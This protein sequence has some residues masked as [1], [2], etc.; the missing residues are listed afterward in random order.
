[1]KTDYT[2]YMKLAIRLAQKA[3]GMTSPNPLVGAVIIDKKGKI[4]G[5]GFH[6]MA[7]QPHA[8]IMALRDAGKVPADST[9]VVTLEPCNHFGR[10]PPCT[11]AI[12]Q[13][14]I[15]RVVIAN[16]DPNPDVEGG[17]AAYLKKA[18]IEVIDG[19]CEQDA[20]R[21]NEAYF[22][23]VKTS[24]PFVSLKL[25]MSLDG[26]IAAH[27]GSSKW[28]TSGYSRRIAH[29]LRNIVDAVIVGVGTVKMDNPELTVRHVKVR[30]RPLYRIIFD[31][32]LSTP[33]NSNV[34]TNQNN[35]YKTMIL[36]ASNNN[37]LINVFEHKDVEVI[38][39]KTNGSVLSV[40]EALNFLG[41][42]FMH[43]LVEGGAG[44]VGSLVKARRVDKFHVF[45]APKIIGADGVYPFKGVFLKNM[46]NVIE[47]KDVKV[48]TH[49]GDCLVQ[50]YPQW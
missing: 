39:M 28:I 44:L 46:N 8:E 22:K 37:A 19:V 33:V 6:R 9:M 26:M 48:S 5:K 17:G 29:K 34:I 42:R 30:G 50:G 20:A 16:K 7:G 24:L 32:H 40:E 23:H 49:D 25:A 36:T 3:E 35:V 1:M 14:G 31:T 38:R 27:D 47:L 10:T 18:G 15:K 45:I 21:L 11:L 41:K 2:P 13:S 12:R 4:I 43:I